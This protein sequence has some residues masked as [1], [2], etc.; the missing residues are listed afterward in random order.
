MMRPE[1]K[2]EDPL[3]MAVDEQDDPAVESASRLDRISVLPK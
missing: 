2:T 1:N 3:G